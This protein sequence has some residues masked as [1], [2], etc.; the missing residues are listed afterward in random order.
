MHDARP[1]DGVCVAGGRY[2]APM[3]K[4]LWTR[5]DSEQRERVRAFVDFLWRRFVADRCF[6]TAGALS[7]T[8]VFALVPLSAV[9]FGI[10]SA[11][12]VFAQWSDQLGDFVF[13]HFVPSAART[14]E[15]YLTRFTD[16]AS[17]L[18]LA[19]TLALIASALLTLASIESTFNRIW[20]VESPRP[21][22]IRFLVYWTVLTLGALLAASTLA[23]SARFYALSAGQAQG[24]L[25]RLVRFLP[26]LIEWL[27]FSTAYVVIPNRPVAWRH[28]LAGGLLAT[29]LFEAS[30]SGLSLYLRSVPGYQQIYGALAAIPIS[31][32]WLY[33]SWLVVL[34]GASLAASLSAFRFQPASRRLPT[35]AEFYGLLRLL[36]R[37]REAQLAGRALANGELQTLEP[38]LSDDLLQHLLAELQRTRIV[39]RNERGAWLLACEL[40]RVTLADLHQGCRLRIP[41]ESL[42][43]PYQDDAIGQAAMRAIED[44]RQPLRAG[45]ARSV[46]SLFKSLEPPPQ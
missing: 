41:T 4:R 21:R 35:G 18:T 16:S 38:G 42:H 33:L 29:L 17:R 37:L 3:F 26:T 8:T 45:L 22:L 40:D 12:P 34:L 32:L 24:L 44:V 10:L 27:A 25:D 9:A 11:F 7:Y 28:A 39:Q 13:S 20:R 46:G 19:G 5:I 30:K 23:L 15:Q 31:L 6:E 43:P 14:V 36:G 1:H 2:T